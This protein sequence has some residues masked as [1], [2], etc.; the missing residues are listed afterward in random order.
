MRDSQGYARRGQ[1]ELRVQEART[2]AA[3]A[4]MGEG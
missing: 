1:I 2:P 4:C 3:L